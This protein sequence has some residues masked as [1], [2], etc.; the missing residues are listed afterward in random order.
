M[1]DKPGLT[2]IAH[3]HYKAPTKP[4][5][6]QEINIMYHNPFKNI[7]GFTPKKTRF[8]AHLKGNNIMTMTTSK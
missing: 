5:P 3:L 4:L 2:V 6:V 8:V 1:V 7:F